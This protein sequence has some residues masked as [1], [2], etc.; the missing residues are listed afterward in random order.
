MIP[1]IRLTSSVNHYAA[2]AS[3][4]RGW[5]SMRRPGEAVSDPRMEIDIKII[6]GSS[7]VKSSSDRAYRRP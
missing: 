7:R 5:I 1:R 2:R 4:T 3:E 6:K